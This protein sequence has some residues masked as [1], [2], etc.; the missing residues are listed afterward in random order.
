MATRLRNM[1]FDEVSF[2]RRGANQHADVVLY[3]ADSCGHKGAGKSDA[4]CQHPC[5]HTSRVLARAMLTA[6]TAVMR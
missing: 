3:K 6:P 2:V 4:Y 5:G 1:K